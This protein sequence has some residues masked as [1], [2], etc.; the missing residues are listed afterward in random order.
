VALVETAQLTKRFGDRTVVD[1]VT[2]SVHAG[3]IFGF[4]GKN[5]AGKSTFI[6]MLT[7]IIRPTS[8]TIRMFDGAGRPDDWKRRIGV[9]PDYSTFYDSLTALDHL[10]YLARVKGIRLSKRECERILEDVGLAE[11]A[12]RKAKTFSFGMKKK[13][14]IAQALAGDPELLFLDEPTSGVDVESALQ[15]QQLLLRL[16]KQGKTIFMTSHNLHEVEKIC[17]RIAIMKAGKIASLGSLA[18]LQAAHRSWR[19]VRVRHSQ[20]AAEQQPELVAFAE[21]IGRHLQWEEGRFSLQVDD[22]Q[23]VAALVRALVQA[24]VDIYG[25]HVEEPSLERIFL[26][27]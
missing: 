26:E 19:T 9:L 27:E 8:G 16:H 15:I 2:L 20:F 25:V 5:G 11:H 7:G 22:D 10:R 24:R 18:D 17:T 12:G 4:L 6:N 14:G 3:E 1:G 13:L 21:R 23:N